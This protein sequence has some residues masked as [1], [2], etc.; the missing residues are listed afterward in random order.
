[1]HR[2]IL[3]LIVGSIYLL[4]L[5]IIAADTAGPAPLLC[6][7]TRAFECYE[8]EGCA[9]VSVTDLDLPRFFSIDI[10]QKKV[11]GI[12]EGGRT[13]VI[14]NMGEVDG[15]IILQGIEQAVENV[16]AG[17]GWT[18]A[19]MNESGNMVLNASGDDAGFVVFGACIGIRE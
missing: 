1:M 17:V 12:K 18:A 10:P 19:I 7:L 3:T 9:P 11:M 13:S 15:R 4:P 2:F 14:Q 16:G 6:S 5:D 8:N